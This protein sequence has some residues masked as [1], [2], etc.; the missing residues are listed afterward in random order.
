MDIKPM[1]ASPLEGEVRFP[2]LASP[3]LDGVRCLV[4][5]G[6]AMSRTLKEIPNAHVQRLFGRRSLNGL[7]GE[8]IVGP[9]NAADAYRRTMS[10]VMSEDGEPDVAFHV[11]DDFTQPHERF[12]TRLRSASRRGATVKGVMCVYHEEFTDRKSLDRYEATVVALG[13]E[14]VM[15]RDPQ[16]P[17]KFGRSTAKEGWLLKLKRFEDGEAV[18]IGAVEEMANNNVAQY[19]EL[20]HLE[21][22]SHKAGKLG[23]GTLGALNVRDVKTGVEFDIGSGFTGEQRRDL[24]KDMKLIGKVVRYRFQPTGVK[25]KPR[26]PVFMGFRDARDL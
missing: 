3:K 9:A 25:D 1:L 22:S 12:S 17:Y 16:A 7:D 18:V 14:G 20:G 24:W 10:G 6:V 13:Y 8:L 4:V 11:F 5:D 23:K 2:V 19:N 26:F 15:L 21:R